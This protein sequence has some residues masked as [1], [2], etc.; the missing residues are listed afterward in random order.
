MPSPQGQLTA[1][2]GTVALGVFDPFNAVLPL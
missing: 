2:P 1:G